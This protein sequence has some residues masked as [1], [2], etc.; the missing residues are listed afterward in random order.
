MISKRQRLLRKLRN[1]PR[2]RAKPPLLPR[3][4]PTVSPKKRL[5]LPKLL[6]PKLKQSADV[7]RTKPTRPK[8]RKKLLR[9]PLPPRPQRKK[10]RLRP[11]PREYAKR[12]RQKP[13]QRLKEFAKKKKM[14]LLQRPPKPQRNR[15]SKKRKK[16][17]RRRDRKMKQRLP[18]LL[19]QPRLV[20]KPRVKVKQK[21][22]PQ[23]S[24]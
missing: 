3:L 13:R 7:N 4:S 5:M 6:R 2:R 10:L 18:K 16:L 1:W 21:S 17:P 23:L 11:R 15:D 8:Q 14:L 22:K 24:P 12:R 9:L 19:P 20:M